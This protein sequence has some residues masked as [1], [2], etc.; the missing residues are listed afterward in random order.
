MKLRG[1]Q[2]AGLAQPL[3]WRIGHLIRKYMGW[4]DSDGPRSGTVEADETFIG[5]KDK[6]GQDDKFTVLGMAQRGGEILTRVVRSKRLGDMVP[7]ILRQVKTGSKI[8]TEEGR[9][10]L[11]LS[12]AG[13]LH[14]TVNH[15]RK[16]WTCGPVH[17]DI[18]EAFRLWLKRGIEGTDVSV[19]DKHLLV[20]RPAGSRCRRRK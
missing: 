10:F 18:I 13:H 7:H 6:R 15:K 1:A 14:G 9:S 12:T 17:T 3:A 4:V 19:S 5:D 20:S 2:P 11:D 16:E 8:A